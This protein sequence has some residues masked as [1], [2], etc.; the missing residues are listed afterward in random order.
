MRSPTPSTGKVS[1]FI[2]R[3]FPNPIGLYRDEACNQTFGKA[4]EKQNQIIILI[5]TNKLQTNIYIVQNCT[6]TWDVCGVNSA[7]PTSPYLYLV[8]TSYSSTYQWQVVI[9]VVTPL[10]PLA[11]NVPRSVIVPAQQKVI[12]PVTFST[13]GLGV[14]FFSVCFFFFF[15]QSFSFFIY[16]FLSLQKSV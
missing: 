10:S 1:M 13:T 11:L 16:L 5:I 7:Q 8:V 3:G 6:M 9:N 15:N 14:S 12:I 2:S 4:S